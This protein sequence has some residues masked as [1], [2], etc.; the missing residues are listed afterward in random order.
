[1]QTSP[2]FQQPANKLSLGTQIC[3]SAWFP[4]FPPTTEI[5]V[6]PAGAMAST[7]LTLDLFSFPK[8]RM[9]IIYFS[10]SLLLVQTDGFRVR[11]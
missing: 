5:F 8:T 6:Y 4:F 3:L 7:S 10:S 2:V 9:G 1:M 11:C